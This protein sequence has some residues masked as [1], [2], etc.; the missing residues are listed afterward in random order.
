M[1]GLHDPSNSPRQLLLHR[2]LKV[3]SDVHLRGVSMRWRLPG[4]TLQRRG[5]RRQRAP[6]TSSPPPPTPTSLPVHVVLLLSSAVA[7]SEW[8]PRRRMWGPAL[9]CRLRRGQSPHCPARGQQHSERAV[10]RRSDMRSD[11]YSVH[12]QSL[13]GA[14]GACVCR[15]RFIYGRLPLRARTRALSHDRPPWVVHVWTRSQ[16]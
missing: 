4:A 6:G 3:S 1:R 11:V 7:G 2:R 15:W 9:D 14:H 16:L 13:R 5:R 12:T 10:R 8:R